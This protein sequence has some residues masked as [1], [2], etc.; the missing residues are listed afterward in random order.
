MLPVAI[1]VAETSALQYKE[2]QALEMFK[3]GITRADR[4]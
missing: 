2:I 3:R 4:T 1:Y